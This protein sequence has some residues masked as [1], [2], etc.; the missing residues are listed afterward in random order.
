M[1][2]SATEYRFGRASALIGLKRW[3]DAEKSCRDGLAIHP[4]LAE[5]RILLAAALRGQNKHTQARAEAEAGFALATDPATQ[6]ALR[7]WL[8]RQR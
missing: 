5:G 1:N 8:D 3:A 7:K 6:D 2:P 4:L